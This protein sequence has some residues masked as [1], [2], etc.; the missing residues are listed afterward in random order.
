[1]VKIIE[2]CPNDDYTINV[3]LDNGRA[4]FLD[5]KSY[6][7]IGVFRELKDLAYFKSVKNFGRYIAWP[8]EQ[9]LCADSIAASIR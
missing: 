9:D 1:V 5:L 8:H 6:L 7:E 2:I 4:G 3:V